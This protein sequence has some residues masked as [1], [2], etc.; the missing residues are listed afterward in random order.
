MQ[1]AANA[2]TSTTQYNVLASE[3][4][5]TPFNM[6]I[7]LSMRI[8]FYAIASNSLAFIL[9]LSASLPVSACSIMKCTLYQCNPHFVFL[10]NFGFACALYSQTLS[11][12]IFALENIIYFP[13]N[14][15]RFVRVCVCAFLLAHLARSF[16]NHAFAIP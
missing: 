9:S 5:C 1:S 16:F 10:V 7:M 12:V 3:H 15:F 6:A 14:F 13:N 11:F 8:C 4:S 2:R